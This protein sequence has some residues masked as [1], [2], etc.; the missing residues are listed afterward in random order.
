MQLAKAWLQ[1]HIRGTL[2]RYEV[3]AMNRLHTL[4]FLLIAPTC[5]QM[6]AWAQ[7]QRCTDA[8]GHVTY[9]NAPCQPG[10]RSH[11]LIP[12]SSPQERAQQ[13]AQYQQALER[14]REAQALQLQRDAALAQQQASAAERRTRPVV[15]EVNTPTPAPEVVY[16]PL[17]PPPPP[18]YV[19]PP[20]PPH[21]P[22]PPSTGHHCNVFR[23]YDGQGNTWNRP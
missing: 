21:P 1:L 2:L 9:T 7:V 23:C 22:H 13:E 11:E 10:Q 20:A 18:A 4:L 19:P 3:L 6:P 12:P 8:S 5:M 14:R 15:V 16:S 17:Y